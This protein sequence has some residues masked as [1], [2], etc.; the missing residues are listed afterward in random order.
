[1][2]WAS[3]NFVR[4][5]C[6][7]LS[8]PEDDKWLIVSCNAGTSVSAR[9]LR[10]FRWSFSIPVGL[11]ACDTCTCFVVASTPTS[12]SLMQPCLYRLIHLCFFILH[13][14]NIA[15]RQRPTHQPILEIQPFR[16]VLAIVPWRTPSCMQSLYCP[17]PVR[18]HLVWP[19][20]QQSWSAQGSGPNKEFWS[21]AENHLKQHTRSAIFFHPLL[22]RR[23][24]YF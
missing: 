15:I 6:H 20:P 9:R 4:H 22:S 13:R 19:L 14:G 8:S 16:K 7:M 1:M 2:S 11:T 23:E 24:P 17:L 5:S 21:R 12:Q 10:Q 3:Q 18:A